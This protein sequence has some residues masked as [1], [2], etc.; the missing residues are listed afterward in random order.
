MYNKRRGAHGQCDINA[1][2]IRP[3]KCNKAS[4]AHSS[5][6]DTDIQS[7]E[8]RY[9]KTAASACNP[10]ECQHYTRYGAHCAATWEAN[11]HSFQCVHV[12]STS[13][14]GDGKER[15]LILR[16]DRDSPTRD[17]RSEQS[18]RGC[19]CSAGNGCGGGGRHGPRRAYE[20][21]LV[22][23]S[24][25]RGRHAGAA[26]YSGQGSAVSPRRSYPQAPHRPRRRRRARRAHGSRQSPASTSEP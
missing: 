5:R 9:A 17:R 19:S 21:L 12:S 20:P 1:C 23:P 24:P 22:Q 11:R 26:P 13:D 8:H 15:R 3:V 25:F 4:G 6:F 10:S 2:P 18:R 7:L 16:T 14:R